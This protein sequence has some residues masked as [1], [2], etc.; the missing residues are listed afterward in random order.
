MLYCLRNHPKWTYAAR[1]T[2]TGLTMSDDYISELATTHGLQH[3]RA[4]KRLELI[5]EVAAIRLFWCK[6]RAQWKTKK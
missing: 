3:W 6:C 2:A 1:R 5:D 4:K